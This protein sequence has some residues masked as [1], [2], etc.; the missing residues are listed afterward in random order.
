MKLDL[1][2]VCRSLPPD[3]EIERGEKERSRSENEERESSNIESGL[4][5]GQRIDPRRPLT[6]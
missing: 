6:R 2:L 3:H 4:F 1:R 5:S